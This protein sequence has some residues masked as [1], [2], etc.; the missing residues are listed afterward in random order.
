MTAVLSDVNLDYGQSD[1]D[2]VEDINSIIQKLVVVLGTPY[3]SAKWKPGFGCKLYSRL[4]D[5]FDSTTAGWIGVD[6]DAAIKNPANELVGLLT[7]FRSVVVAG[8]QTYTCSLFFKALLPD[9]TKTDSVKYNFE[10]KP[11]G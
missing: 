8:S 9:G 2:T 5:P 3:N 10:L 4:F 11:L 7:E 6:I 1:T